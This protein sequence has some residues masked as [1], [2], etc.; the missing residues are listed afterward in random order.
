M[1]PLTLERLARVWTRTDRGMA[2]VKGMTAWLTSYSHPG[3]RR[4]NTFTVTEFFD[5]YEVVR[6]KGTIPLPHEVTRED[7]SAYAHWLHHRQTGLEEVRLRRDPGQA[8]EAK[9]YAIVRTQQGVRYDAIRRALLSDPEVPKV[10]VDGETV[11]ELE[12]DNPWDL[13]I[14]LA[15]MVERRLLQRSPTMAELRS[16][17]VRDDVDWSRAG[18]DFRPDPD[19]Y[20][21]SLA[22]HTDAI[23]EDRASTVLRKVATLSSLWRWWAERGENNTDAPA[24]LRFNIW[25]PLVKEESDLAPT[26][27]KMYRQGHTPTLEHWQAL[28]STCSSDSIDDIRDRAI[29]MLLLWQGLRVQEL[30]NIRRKHRVTI[31]GSLCVRV[32]RKNGRMQH[33]VLEPESIAALEALDAKIHE[34]AEAG[35]A[36]QKSQ[37][38]RYEAETGQQAP[39]TLP[40]RWR[41]VLEDPEAP[42]IP[43]VVRWGTNA[44]DS[45]EE[46]PIT[47]Q[48][49]AMML[50]RRAA[51]PEDPDVQGSPPVVP[52]ED[53]PKIH[54]HGFRHLAAKEARRAGA[55]VA[56]IQASLGHESLT[57]TSRYVEEHELERTRLFAKVQ[58]QPAYV[59][60]SS[61]QNDRIPV[62][63]PPRRRKPVPGIID[64]G[65]GLVGD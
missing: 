32:R 3:T 41:R 10:R 61:G 51:T 56:S 24:P 58:R 16:L 60:P 31:D 59:D 64:A 47:R 36:R 57:T 29:L 28:V 63:Q 6:K 8:I 37:A 20:R 40:P 5:W 22:E 62:V 42:L 13:D 43:A 15:K 53:W 39:A 12:R 1:A 19:T 18:I 30:C 54:P 65:N 55:D 17:G 26:R 23:G 44:E 48:A 7:A 9:V 46:R 25:S 33:L 27:Q 45:A 2:F 35:E 50:R 52:E 34:L 21:Y 4:S 11:L 14:L 38:K 49:V